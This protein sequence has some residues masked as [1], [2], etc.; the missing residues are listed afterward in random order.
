MEKQFLHQSEEEVIMNL[1][2][3][4]QILHIVNHSTLVQN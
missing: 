4:L 1:Y 3:G 2:D